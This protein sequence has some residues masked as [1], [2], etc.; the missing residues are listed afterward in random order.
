MQTASDPF[1]GWTRLEGRDY[2]VRQLCDHK[3]KIET[4]ELHG[5][6]LVA[7]ATVA[8]EVLAKGHARTGSAPAIAGYCGATPRLDR[9]MAAFA[10]AY[11]DQTTRDHALLVQ[12]IRAKKVKAV[13]TL[14]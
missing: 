13:R 1:R 8:G 3:A 14:R 7:Y 2:L 5:E 10:A 4:E 9:A 6:A 11:A 12:A